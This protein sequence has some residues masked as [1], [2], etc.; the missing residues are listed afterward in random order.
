MSLKN[1][2]P[3]LHELFTYCQREGAIPDSWKA[4]RLVL[5][6]KEGKGLRYPDAYRPISIL[7]SDYRILA[8]TLAS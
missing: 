1:V 3:Y 7:N 6:P 4:V 5:I 2:S 8:T